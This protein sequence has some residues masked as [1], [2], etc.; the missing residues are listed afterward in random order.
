MRKW[1]K[2]FDA[3]MVAA[4]FAE[5]GEFETAKETLKEKRK[6]LLALTGE[7]SDRNAFK[8]ALNTSRR[9]GA[10][11]DILYVADIAK[12][13]LKR[14]R[15][16]L[17]KEG[18]DYSI[19]HKKGSLEKEIRNHTDMKRDILF[20]VVEISEDMN[21][22]TKKSEKIIKDAWKNL[23]CPLVVVAQNTNAFAT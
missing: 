13:T 10:E 6:I 11:L 16:A 3:A 23:H 19:I 15:S 17:D 7:A 14:Y 20:V 9:I 4:A 18:I 5:A 22:N 12:D 8:Y 1:L 2:K 21:I